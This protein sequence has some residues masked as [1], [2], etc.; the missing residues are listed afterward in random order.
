MPSRSEEAAIALHVSG[1]HD[2]GED[3]SPLSWSLHQNAPGVANEAA[4]TINISRRP[5]RALPQFK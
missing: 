4:P 1:D 2:S 5:E 3:C